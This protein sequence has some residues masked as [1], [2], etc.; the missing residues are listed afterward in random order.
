MTTF[1]NVYMR[2]AEDHNWEVRFEC[3]ILVVLANAPA[4]GSG[5]QERLSIPLLLG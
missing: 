4:Q 5:L 1:L 3:G 2:N